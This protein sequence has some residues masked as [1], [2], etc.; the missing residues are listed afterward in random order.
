MG[1]SPAPV[2][3]QL[4][5]FSQHWVAPNHVGIQPR[6]LQTQFQLAQA[7]YSQ[8]ENDSDRS[9]DSNVDPPPVL[10]VDYEG[11]F[12]DSIRKECTRR[13]LKLKSSM[14]KTERIEVLRR[15]DIART[16][17]DERLLGDGGLPQ[18]KNAAS[19]RTKHCLY[20]FL[21]ILFSDEFSTRYSQTVSMNEAFFWQGVR[22]VFVQVYEP[23]HER[24]LLAFRHELF[25]GVDPSII[26]PHSEKKLYDMSKEL[27]RNYFVVEQRF[28]ASGQHE[29]EF[30]DYVDK[31]GAVLYLRMWLEVR[32]YDL[33]ASVPGFDGIL[34]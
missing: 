1:I 12:A 28:T 5:T 7:G 34:R 17:Y 2:I 29:N 10:S 21:N 14:K 4:Q 24:N 22:A 3:S 11:W 26:R 13:G 20:R 33:V 23:N 32:C 8:H 19:S 15:H 18:G 6:S 30:P 27:L 25:K 16:V 9:N 31:R